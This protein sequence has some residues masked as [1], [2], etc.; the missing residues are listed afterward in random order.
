MK[1][2]SIKILRVIAS[3]AFEQDPTPNCLKLILKHGSTMDK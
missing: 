3:H 1:I 2:D